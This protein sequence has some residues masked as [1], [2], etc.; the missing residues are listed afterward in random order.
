M[1]DLSIIATEGSEAA[2]VD[3][4]TSPADYE[5]FKKILAEE[6]EPLPRMD[7]CALPNADAA[8]DSRD[9]ATEEE[10]DAAM[11]V[12]LMKALGVSDDHD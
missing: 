11:E 10:A 5:L 2:L 3:N 4:A 7:S 9:Y 8:F 6:D 12:F 1:A